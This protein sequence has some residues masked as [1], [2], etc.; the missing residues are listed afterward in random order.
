MSKVYA[1]ESEAKNSNRVNFRTF[2]QA[3]EQ[4]IQAQEKSR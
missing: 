2:M 4:Q 3:N 1:M